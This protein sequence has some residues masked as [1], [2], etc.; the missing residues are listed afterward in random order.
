MSLLVSRFDPVLVEPFAGFVGAGLFD[1]AFGL[2]ASMR[3]AVGRRVLLGL[4]ALGVLARGAEINEIAHA[5]PG[6]RR[7]A[8]RG[9]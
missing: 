5:E 7:H 6:I 2:R 3:E 8:S 9:N 1:G 4:S